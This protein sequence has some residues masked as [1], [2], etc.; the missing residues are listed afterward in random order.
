M[1]VLTREKVI[2]SH[3]LYSSSYIFSNIDSC[4]FRVYP[5]RTG[6]YDV[7][8]HVVVVADD[9]VVATSQYIVSHI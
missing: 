9:F 7:T 8:E 6:S 4:S 1:I 5:I 2:E 3:V